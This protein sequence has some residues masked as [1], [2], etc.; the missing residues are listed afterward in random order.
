MKPHDIYNAPNWVT[1]IGTKDAEDYR[2]RKNPG[3]ARRRAETKNTYDHHLVTSPDHY[4][5]WLSSSDEPVAMVDLDPP[6]ERKEAL[7]TSSREEKRSYLRNE[8]I[9]SLPDVFQRLVARNYTEVSASGLGLRCFMAAKFDKTKYSKYIKTKDFEGQVNLHGDMFMICTQDVFTDGPILNLTEK[10]LHE[11]F[12]VKNKGSE[13]ETSNESCNNTRS[14][15]IEERQQLLGQD[16]Y[17]RVLRLPIDQNDKIKKVWH[18]L[19][20]SEYQHYD[21]WLHVAM[22]LHDV[23][24]LTHTQE[25]AFEAF[26]AWS[27]LDE[28]CYVDEDD[29]RKTWDACPQNDQGITHRTLI[30]L[31]KRLEF[32]WPHPVI[33]KSGKTTGKPKVNRYENFEYLMR[34]FGIQ[35]YKTSSYE[36]YLTGAEDHLDNFFALP[37]GNMIIKGK[38]L[39]RFYGPFSDEDLY[40]RMFVFCQASGYDD[41][42]GR[43]KTKEMVDA[44]LSTCG[45]KRFNIMHEWLQTPYDELPNEL[46]SEGVRGGASDVSCY[47]DQSNLAYITSCVTPSPRM[48]GGKEGCE[49]AI[50]LFFMGVAK[51]LSNINTPQ[52]FDENAG[53]LLLIGAEG[54][55]KTSFFKSLLPHAL[56]EH[57]VLTVQGLTKSMGSKSMRDM[58]RYC[59]KS[60]FVVFD[61]FD[62]L[63]KEFMQSEMKKLISGNTVEFTEI[64]QKT[65]VKLPRAAALGG[66][67]N[68]DKLIMSDFGNRRLWPLMVQYI[69]TSALI[70]VNW[71]LFYNNLVKEFQ[72]AVNRGK[73]PWLPTKDE[74]ETMKSVQHKVAASTGWEKIFEELF[75]TS[76]EFPGIHSITNVQKESPY[77]YGPS[78]VRAVF[79]AAGY[80]IQVKDMAAFERALTRFSGKYSRLA[81]KEGA[82]PHAKGTYKGGLLESGKNGKY[83]RWILPPEV[84]APFGNME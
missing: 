51:L 2:S 29:C 28:S 8:F 36:Y 68:S 40:S 82:L 6:K 72:E 70:K 4:I 81:G 18:D 19:T 15:T 17:T 53:L 41:K 11:H 46:K 63:P 33:S 37:D 61:E 49:I 84:G 31:L 14:L 78:S 7:I 57:C 23:G 44:Y 71:H 62:S 39:G 1:A 42:I 80:N 34:Y 9:P 65:A 73:T 74:L 10:F 43:H 54:V 77:L 67:T 52:R 75:D 32:A 66:T 25:E 5:G 16:L 76:Q 83:K 27:Q 56:N 21:Y 45:C 20:G 22:A 24:T 79:S 38:A 59:A 48:P 30:E 26:H 50:R 58:Y 3:S 12:K 69:D 64:Y 60:G 35:L 55:Y 13:K 47:N